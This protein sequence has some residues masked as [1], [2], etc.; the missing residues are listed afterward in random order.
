MLRRIRA[1]HFIWRYILGYYSTARN[2]RTVSNFHARHNHGFR[3]NPN[4]IANDSVARTLE[5]VY[6]IREAF[7]FLVEKWK[8]TNPVI[9]MA[10]VSSHHKYG[11]R[12]YGAIA[13]DYQLIYVISIRT[14]ITR[15]IIEA[16]TMIIARVVAMFANDNIWI[17][18][19]F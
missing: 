8:C 1:H 4:I 9:S 18:H 7:I 6:G 5:A 14:K 15:T 19:L 13:T 3:A 17:R 16:M 10:L 12:T 11:T 2:N